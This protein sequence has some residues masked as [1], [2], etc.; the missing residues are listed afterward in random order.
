[1]DQTKLKNNLDD[2]VMSCVNGVGV[3]VNTASKQL[4]T[5][6]SGLGPVLAQNIVD[7]RNENGPFKS[8]NEL[9]KVARLGAKAY[10]Q[11]A[12]FLRIRDAK[13]PLDASAVHPES[14]AVVEQM[15]K[16]LGCKVQDIIAKEELRNQIDLKKYVT[17]TVGLPTLTDI[18]QE[19]AKPGR[20]PRE[21]FEAIAFA[22]GINS[23]ADLKVGMK[24]SGIV[25]NVTNFGAFV[26]IGVHQDGLV[27]ISQLA[28]TFVSDPS[29]FVKVQQQVEVTVTEVDVARKRIALSMKTGVTNIPSP[30]P[31]GVPIVAK[32]NAIK[33]KPVS[34]PKKAEEPLND[35]QAK[36]MALQGKFK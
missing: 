14:Y 4:L 30:K 22:E 35:L 1:V 20:D 25:T 26:D 6:V 21:V 31:T 9:K 24:L 27:H 8:K 12:G 29:K 3:E 33:P 23:M 10:E 19:L 7:Y 28:D 2:V 36:L 18:V 5:Y 32:A 13:H 16:D 11:A 34:S 15:A 17:A